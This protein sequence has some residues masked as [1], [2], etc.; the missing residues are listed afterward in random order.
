MKSSL[1]LTTTQ[2]DFNKMVLQALK[3]Q[4]VGKLDG[5]RNNFVDIA[6]KLIESAIK[7][8]PT[9]KSIIGGILLYQLGLEH[10][11]QK[12]QAI[13]D[14]WIDSIECR[15]TKRLSMSSDGLS[16]EMQL[17][18]IDATFTDVLELE[19][20]K[21]ISNNFKGDS[22]I[23]PW[24]QWMLIEGDRIIIADFEVKYIQSGFSRTQEALMIK[25]NSVGWKVPSHHSGTQRN[26][27]VTRAI[28]GLQEQFENSLLNEFQKVF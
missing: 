6:R 13:I 7:S 26:N 28:E 10:P 16:F 18:A 8:S 11:I 4:L 5:V 3:E 2:S 1:K 25:T 24:L 22:T 21:Q 9:Y 15:I 17:N 12:T 27:F 14:K 19:E 20:S 23:L